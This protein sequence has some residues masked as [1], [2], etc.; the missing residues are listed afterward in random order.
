MRRTEPAAEAPAL[1]G[2]LMNQLRT[3]AVRDHTEGAVEA[4]TA[5]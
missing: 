3:G 1:V 5:S 2:R 4:D